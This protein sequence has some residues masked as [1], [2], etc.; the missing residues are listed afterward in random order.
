MKKGYLKYP[1]RDF[2]NRKEK[3]TMKTDKLKNLNACEEIKKYCTHPL[4]VCCAPLKP[5]KKMCKHC[6]YYK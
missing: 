6:K 4:G 5:N 1:D 3:P 2:L